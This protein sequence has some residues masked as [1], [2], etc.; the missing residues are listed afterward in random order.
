MAIFFGLITIGLF[1]GLVSV[2]RSLYRQYLIRSAIL[3]NQLLLNKLKESSIRKDYYTYT[4]LVNYSMCQLQE[5]IKKVHPRQ[6]E[7]LVAKEI[8]QIIRDKGFTEL[9]V[10]DYSLKFGAIILIPLLLGVTSGA[11]MNSLSLNIYN[12]APLEAEATSGSASNLDMK[13]YQ[14]YTNGL[15]AIAELDWETASIELSRVHENSI[16]RE[17]AKDL[18]RTAKKE[19]IYKENFLQA[20]SAVTAKRFTVAKEIL[21]GIPADSLYY[22][23]AQTILNDL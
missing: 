3:E 7:Q 19:R 13:S 14:A 4:Q 21:R 18:L 12:K 16:Y 9:L 10:N 5:K 11:T 20:M 8:N 1:I 6:L 22:Q 2:C 17:E 23:K 15:E